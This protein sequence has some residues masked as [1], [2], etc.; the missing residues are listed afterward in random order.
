MFTHIVKS[1]LNNLSWVIISG[2]ICNNLRLHKWT[3]IRRDK[4]GENILQNIQSTLIGLL[5]VR[6]VKMKMNFLKLQKC[7]YFMQNSR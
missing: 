4:Y 7:H 6:V 3:Q 2:Y 5:S 1:L